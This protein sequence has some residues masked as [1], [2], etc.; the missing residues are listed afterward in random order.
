MSLGASNTSLS[1]KTE[2]TNEDRRQMLNLLQ[3]GPNTGGLQAML[4]SGGPISADNMQALITKLR[5]LDTQNQMP[6]TLKDKFKQIEKTLD[7]FAQKPKDN[8]PDIKDTLADFQ[9][10]QLLTLNGPTGGAQDMAKDLL[11]T[12]MQAELAGPQALQSPNPLEQGPGLTLQNNQSGP[13]V[14]ANRV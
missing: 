10:R 8:A 7:L 14:S 4:M 12:K 2:F 1:A 11:G 13:G 9:L 3:T 5:E 6:E